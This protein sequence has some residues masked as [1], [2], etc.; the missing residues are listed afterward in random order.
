MPPS[1]TPKEFG[2]SPTEHQ[3]FATLLE[4]S[5]T[6]FAQNSSNLPSLQVQR[7]KCVGLPVLPPWAVASTLFFVPSCLGGLGGGD[8]GDHG[9]GDSRPAMPAMP[10]GLTMI[11]VLAKLVARAS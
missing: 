1:I 11:V 10:A 5:Q 6:L 4:D 9:F 3:T 2:N 7:P 8:P